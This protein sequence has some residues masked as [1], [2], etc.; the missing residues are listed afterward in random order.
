[1]TAQP[2]NRFVSVSWSWRLSPNGNQALRPLQL[3]GDQA[4]NLQAFGN[5]GRHYLERGTTILLRGEQLFYC[6]FQQM[7]YKTVVQLVNQNPYSYKDWTRK[8]LQYKDQSYWS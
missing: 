2:H 4:L 8:I 1:M 3:Y 6:W 7:Y 5:F